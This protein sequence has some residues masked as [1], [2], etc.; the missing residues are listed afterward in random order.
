MSKSAKAFSPKEFTCW[1]KAESA[2]G[3][4]VLGTSMLQN[5]LVGLRQSQQQ[6][7]VC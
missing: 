4:S 2:A 3:T 5:L 6:E 7:Q 1:V